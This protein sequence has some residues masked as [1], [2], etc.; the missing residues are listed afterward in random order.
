MKLPQ[1]TPRQRKNGYIGLA[2]F[3]MVIIFGCIGLYSKNHQSGASYVPVIATLPAGFGT[4]TEIGL[5]ILDNGKPG[6]G[7]VNFG[8]DSCPGEIGG[9]YGY[10]WCTDKN[11]A[12]IS[13]GSVSFTSYADSDNGITYTIIPGTENSFDMLK[14]PGASQVLLNAV[15]DGNGA[16][17]HPYHEVSL[18]MWV[19]GAWVDTQNGTEIFLCG[20]AE[21]D[22][23]SP[24]P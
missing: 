16:T 20:T 21:A 14:V 8:S 5:N 2:V 18:K 4:P 24:T 10:F 11:G 3:I 6:Y 22:C 19:N 1:F 23:T 9:T 12:G 15:L 7:V 17:D 13:F